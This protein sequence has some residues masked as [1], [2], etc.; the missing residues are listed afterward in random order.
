MPWVAAELPLGRRQVDSNTR[1]P[2]ADPTATRVNQKLLG[3]FVL[4][5]SSTNK[6]SRSYLFG[7]LTQWDARAHTKKQ[8][9]LYQYQRP[10][11]VVDEFFDFTKNIARRFCSTEK[12]S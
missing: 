9:E 4:S 8:L 11:Y 5:A 12:A 6:T 2:N 3:P 7:K 10:S 1:Q